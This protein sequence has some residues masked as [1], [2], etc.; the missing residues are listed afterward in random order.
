MVGR[1]WGLLQVSPATIKQNCCSA[2]VRGEFFFG[3]GAFKDAL[4]HDTT[5]DERLRPPNT[6]RKRDEILGNVPP[7]RALHAFHAELYDHAIVR[8]SLNDFY[9]R[10]PLGFVVT[11][12]WEDERR[13]DDA[14]VKHSPNIILR[15]V[16]VVL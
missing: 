8:V 7:P 2:A 9:T 14:S 15:S 4:I 5:L 12:A 13:G 10:N 6:L 11:R 1:V 3:S 16:P